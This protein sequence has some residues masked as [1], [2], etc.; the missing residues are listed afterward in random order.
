MTTPR[1]SVII[2]TYNRRPILERCL[3]ALARQT[4]GSEA[5]EVIVVD[6]GSSDGTLAAL[7]EW[8]RALPYVLRPEAQENQGPAA[9]RNRGLAAARAP[10]VLFLGDDI[11]ATP[12]LIEQHLVW[13]AHDPGDELAVLGFIT[14]DP[15]LRI[16]PLMRWL[17][18]SGS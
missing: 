16:T 15:A 4:V 11:L 5:F 6:D 2:P 1:L 13:H 12:A 9:A 10:W 3:G 14:W 18:K 7:A 17:E 8:A